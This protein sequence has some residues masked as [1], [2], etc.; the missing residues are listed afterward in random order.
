[1]RDEGWEI[2]DERCEGMPRD[3]GRDL[4]QPQPWP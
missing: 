1:M 4:T 2:N 3:G